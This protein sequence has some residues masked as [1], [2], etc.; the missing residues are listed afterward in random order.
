MCR[1][2][3]DLDTNQTIFVEQT[4]SGGHTSTVIRSVDLFK[5]AKTSI[6]AASVLEFEV[7][8]DYLFVVKNET[9]REVAVG[10]IVFD[11]S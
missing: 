9:V 10:V 11:V 6:V 1:G 8:D 3:P 2:V 4:D 7:F 5:S